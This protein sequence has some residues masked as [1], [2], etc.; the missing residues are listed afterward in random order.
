MQASQCSIPGDGSQPRFNSLGIRSHVLGAIHYF[1][2]RLV[3]LDRGI[4]ISLMIRFLYYNWLDLISLSDY[5]DI[6]PNTV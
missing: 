4:Y 1:I 3:A 5:T 2:P 6:I